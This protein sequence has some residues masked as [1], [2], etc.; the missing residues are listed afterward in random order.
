MARGVEQTPAGRTQRDREGGVLGE[1]RSSLARSASHV[2]L[3][4]VFSHASFLFH[5]SVR[6]KC[7]LEF[8]KRL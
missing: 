2:L 1:Y 7:F 3:Y 6:V 5:K 8:Y 4:S